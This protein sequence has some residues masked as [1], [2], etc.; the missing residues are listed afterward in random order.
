MFKLIFFH[1][2]FKPIKPER[3]ES[4]HWVN[5]IFDYWVQWTR[6]IVGW[7]GACPTKDISIKFNIQPKC[8]VLWFKMHLT[9]HNQTWHMSLQCNCCELCNISLGLIMYILNWSIPN[10]GQISNSIEISLVGQVLGLIFFF[11]LLHTLSP[12]SVE[13]Q[14]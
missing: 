2:L 7:P 8:A 11:D 9:N 14:N 12:V 4:W 10:V 13:L 1:P 6:I 3:L 5:W